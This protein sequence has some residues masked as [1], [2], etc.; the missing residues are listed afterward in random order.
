MSNIK[1]IPFEAEI[2]KLIYEGNIEKRGKLATVH[3]I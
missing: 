1:V 2:G 3:S